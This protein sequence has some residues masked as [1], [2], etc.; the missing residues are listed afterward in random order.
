ME[1]VFAAAVCITSWSSSI[2][3]CCRSGSSSSSSI[4]V[5]LVVILVVVLVAVVAVVVKDG[6]VKIE[7]EE[8]VDITN[9][10]FA[11]SAMNFSLF[12]SV[13]QGNEIF[14]IFFKRRKLKLN[15]NCK[16]NEL[17]HNLMQNNKTFYKKLSMKNFTKK[18]V[19]HFFVIKKEVFKLHFTHKIY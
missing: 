14:C 18:N 5:A 12:F 6:E 3:S 8:V 4:V 10:S 15:I 7:E 9:G 16:N 19:T 17:N 13:I 1:V 11:V 2:G